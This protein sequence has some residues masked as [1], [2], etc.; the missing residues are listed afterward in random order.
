[1][2]FILEF[3]ELP[4]LN[5]FVILKDYS[6]GDYVFLIAITS[7]IFSKVASL[8]ILLLV[9]VCIR[10]RNFNSFRDYYTFY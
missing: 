9:S 3:I 6:L 5:D 7:F 10:F 1:M 2:S 8:L 4:L